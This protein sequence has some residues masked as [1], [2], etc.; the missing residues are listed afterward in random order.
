MTTPSGDTRR[1]TARRP[2]TALVVGG[3]VAGLTAARDLAAAGLRVTLV[4]ASDHFGGAVGAHEVAGLVLDSGA[5]SFATRSTAVPELMAELGLTERMVTPDPAGSW[6]FLPEG[7]VPAPRSGVLGIP[8]DPTAAELRAPLGR[9]GVSRARMDR[10]LPARVGA[11]E[12]TVGGLVRARMGQRVVDRLVA[13]F[14]SGVYSTHPDQLDV[15][16]VAPGLRARMRELGSLGAAAGALRRA[17][18]AGANV[19]GIDGGMNLLSERLVRDAERMGVKLVTRYDVIALDRDPRRPGWMVIQRQPTNGDKTAVARGELLVLAADGPTSVRLM[20]THLADAQNYTPRSGPRIAL[21]TLVL[22]CPALDCAPRGTGVLVSDD[23]RD[24]RA[25]A[26]TH[27]SAKWEWVARAAGEHRHVVRLS[28][29]RATPH[30][31]G[32]SPEVTLEDEHLISLALGDASTLFGVPI[33][34]SQLVGADVVRWHAALPRTDPG[35]VARITGFRRALTDVP[36]AVAVGAWLSG[37]GLAAV[38]T[39]TRQQVRTLLARHGLDVT[40]T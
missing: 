34:P 3:G 9:S 37:T 5:E 36:D 15:D 29:G 7:A 11:G 10:V 35:H 17:S 27:S 26:L 28:Y 4:E 22:E 19:A 20:G 12:R 24:V 14:V 32:P 8:A 33:R 18:P 25:K 40:R 6:L 13:P 30:G 2:R 31:T 38:V 39:D 21:A 23:V 1:T 16:A